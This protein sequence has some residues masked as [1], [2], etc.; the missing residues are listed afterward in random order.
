MGLVVHEEARPKMVSRS[1]SGIF[2]SCSMQDAQCTLE[3]ETL[4]SFNDTLSTIY[5]R[6]SLKL[7]VMKLQIFR[8][9]ASIRDAKSF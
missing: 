9:L 8:C 3:Q 2:L 6:Q 7:S 4:L 1:M 5:D